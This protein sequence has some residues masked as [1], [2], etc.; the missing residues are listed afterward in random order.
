MEFENMACPVCKKKFTSD[1]DIVVCPDCGTPQHRAC[2][3]KESGCY[4]CS[5]PEEFH[6]HTENG[7]DPEAEEENDN[8]ICPRC[9]A[10]CEKGAF[11]CSKCGYPV[12]LNGDTQNNGQPASGVPF[13]N[14]FDPMA[15][16][17]PSE[18]MGDGVT[19]GEISKF[20]QKN[21]VYFMRV[22]GNIK[23]FGRSRFNFCAFL[24]GGGYLLYRKMY[25][26]GAIITGIMLA[27][28]IG[29][30]YVQYSP[31]YANFMTTLEQIASGSDYFSA[32]SNI[33]QA[34]YSMDAGSQLMLTLMSF[35][36]IG[37]LVLEIVL[38][39][40]ANKMYFN[41][42]KKQIKEIKDADESD[43]EQLIESKGGVNIPIAVSIYVVYLIILYVPDILGLGGLK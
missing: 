6:I 3:E 36:S 14:I 40:K 13:N 37:R 32:F 42:C 4:V 29:E 8:I 23:K 17:N 2:Y 43:S 12:G 26:V 28:L 31:V 27:L 11:Y 35:C 22:F 5:H 41:H 30:V 10:E 39:F 33:T 18:D 20:V 19:A 21:T 38:G 1:D 16:V 25:K 15:G 9:G 24:F 34:F 7:F